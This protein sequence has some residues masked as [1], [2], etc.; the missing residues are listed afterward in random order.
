MV[1][2]VRISKADPCDTKQTVLVVDDMPENIELMTAILGEH[3]QVKVALNGA[4]ALTI[5][6]SDNPP[7]IILLDIMMP[8]MD[9]YEVCRRLKSNESSAPIPVIFISAMADIDDEEL[10]LTLGAVDYITKP[11]S[12]PLVLCRVQTQLRLYNQNRHLDQLVQKRSRQLAAETVRREK[13][14]YELRVAREI[15]L[16]MLPE[17]GN[18]GISANRCRLSG[19]LRAAQEVGGDFFNFFPVA[20]NKILFAIGDVS[21]KGV[22]AALFMAKASTLLESIGLEDQSP[23]QIMLKMNLALC[24]NNEESMFVTVGCGMLDTLSG[25]LNYASAGHDPP[26]LIRPGC[27]VRSLDCPGGPLIGI[28]DLATFPLATTK[29]Q[30]GDTLLLYTDG[31]TEA[32]N[33]QGEMFTKE[34][35]FRYLSSIEVQT[36][37]GL[38]EQLIQQVD[39]FSAG[40]D[41]SDDITV[42]AVSFE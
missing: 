41:Q 17:Q 27:P 11:V 1:Q 15:Q 18:N 40:T 8:G 33:A 32:F 19:Q 24:R 42:L 6:H 30:P 5:V 13:I 35:L 7:D 25:D 14:E 23:E 20:E 29:M 10:G 22:P 12:P 2:L 9:G 4:K 3:Y 26:V 36:P 21:G 16:S 39:A 28:D 34:R 37:G 31:I 38:I